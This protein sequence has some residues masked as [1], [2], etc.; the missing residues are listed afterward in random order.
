MI[1]G[2]I[3]IGAQIPLANH[4][5]TKTSAIIY[6]VVD[7]PFITTGLLYGLS[8]L[9]LSLYPKGNAPKILDVFF[10]AIIAITPITLILINILLPNLK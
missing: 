10:I 7:I 6:K 2:T 3:H 4:I 8:S 1:L 9:R 5:F